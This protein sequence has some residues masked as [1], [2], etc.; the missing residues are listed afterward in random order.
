MLSACWDRQSTLEEASLGPRG[1]CRDLEEAV[2]E[3]DLEGLI[4]LSQAQYES[5]ECSGVA[6]SVKLLRREA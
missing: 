4:E 2:L 1:V 5:R 3:L 6:T